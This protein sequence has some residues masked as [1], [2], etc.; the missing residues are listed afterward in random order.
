MSAT[1]DLARLTAE[2]RHHRQRYDLYKAKVYGPRD[3]SE[4]R[5]RELQRMCESAEKRLAEAKA[6]SA[7]G[8]DS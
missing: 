6:R 1:D 2:A 5:L 4:T 3:T 8:H 7:N